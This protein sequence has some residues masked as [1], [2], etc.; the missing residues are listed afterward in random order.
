MSRVTI[1]AATSWELN[2]VLAAGR[3]SE[4]TRVAGVPAFIFPLGQTWCYAVQTGVGPRRAQQVAEAVLG[5]A[6]WDALISTGF[7]G[8]LLETAEIGSVLIGTSATAIGMSSPALPG[9]RSFRCHPAAIRLARALPSGIAEPMMCGPIISTDHVVW[10]TEEKQALAGLHDAVAVDMESA[11]LASVARR[12]DVPFAVVRT[13]SDRVGESLPLDFNLFLRTTGRVAGWFEG[14]IQC[15]RRPA[16]WAGL[17]RLG[18][19]SRRAAERLT[20]FLGP[21]LLSLVETGEFRRTPLS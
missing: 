15:L 5:D 18:L 16:S 1:F 19:D 17:A 14:A 6:R 4:R 20:G 13:I 11:A 9:G 12:H 10:N 2:A 7:A 8:S 21:F 3:G